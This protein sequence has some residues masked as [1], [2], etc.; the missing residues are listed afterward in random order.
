MNPALI[1]GT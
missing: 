1:I